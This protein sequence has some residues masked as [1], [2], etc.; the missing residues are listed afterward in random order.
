M[1]ITWAF[2]GWQAR[3]LRSL[4]ADVRWYRAALLPKDLAA[5]HLMCEQV[6]EQ[7]I[8]QCILCASR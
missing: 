6:S 8:K 7:C 2:V 4:P 3:M 5:M 1:L